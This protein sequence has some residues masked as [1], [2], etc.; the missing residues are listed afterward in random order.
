MAKNHVA[1]LKCLTLPKL[2]LLAAVVASRVAN[3]IID[4]VKLQDTPFYFWRDNQIALH[5]LASTKALPQFVSR[6]VREIK[7]AFPSTTWSYCPTR[8]NPADLLTH[9]VC[10]ELL[11]SPDSLWWKAQ[12]G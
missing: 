3:L 5:W 1:P 6:S 12:H 2:E 8:D 11:S 4:A 7:E 10:F 9:G